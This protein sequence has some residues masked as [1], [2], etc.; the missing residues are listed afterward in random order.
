LNARRRALFSPDCVEVKLLP[1]VA[2]AMFT[3]VTRVLC[4]GSVYWADGPAHIRCILGK[5]YVIQPP[6]Y[7]LFN[8]IAGLFPNPITAISV[9]NILF[10]VAAVVVFYYA[11]ERISG[12]ASIFLDL[13][14]LVFG[15]GP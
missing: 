15:R 2:L 6:G 9:M 10:S 7:W 5:A 8:R 1:P 3:L 12:C 11:K 14:H 4:R 13:F